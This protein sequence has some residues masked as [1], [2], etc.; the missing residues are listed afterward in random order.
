MKV[1]GVQKV[2]NVDEDQD[3]ESVTYLEYCHS[4]EIRSYKFL[5]EES[6][7]QNIPLKIPNI[8]YGSDYSRHHKDGLIIMDDLSG[9]GRTLKL[10]PGLNNEQV[11]AVIDELA[12]IHVICW[13]NNTFVKTNIDKPDGNEFIEAMKQISNQLRD[14]DPPV[15]NPLMD[16]MEKIFTPK[17]TSYVHYKDSQFGGF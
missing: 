7:K 13:K 3:P 12:K 16:R 10:L 2:G 4:N 11:E 9:E 17:V 5:L 1:P 15:F 14:L 6:R 8:Y